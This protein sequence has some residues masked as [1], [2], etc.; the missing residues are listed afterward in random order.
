M[1]SKG[2]VF[3][4]KNN[5]AFNPEMRYVIIDD[6]DPDD[7]T[8]DTAIDIT[9]FSISMK[10]KTDAAVLIQEFSTGAGTITITD[11][12]NGYYKPLLADTSAW[13]E[14]VAKADIV[15]NDVLGDGLNDGTET[16]YLNIMQG[17]T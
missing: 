8:L 14:Q 3:Q 16:F 7:R 11:A 1:A 17:I 4:I 15:L 6:T 13:S 5:S 12:V 10:I 9:G 2:E